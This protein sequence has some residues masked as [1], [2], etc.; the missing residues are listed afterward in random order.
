MFRSLML[1]GALAALTVACA[2]TVDLA[3]EEAALQ[4]IP[5]QWQAFEAEQDAAGVAGLFKD[6]GALYW[7]DQPLARDRAG[8]EAL[9]AKNYKF[10]TGDSSWGVD[11]LLLASSADLAVELGNYSSGSDGGRYA[12]IHQKVD[13][14]WKVHSDFSVGNAPSGGAPEWAVSSLRAWY[15]AYNARDAAAMRAMYSADSRV[16]DTDGMVQG[17]DAIVAR[18]QT[19]WDAGTTCDGDFI[20]FL[21][22][23]PIATAQGRDICTTTAED[24]TTTN[25]YITWITVYEQQADGSWLTIRDGSFTHDS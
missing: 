12:T 24:G 5:Q 23:G 10:P 3:A 6:D 17:P 15:E 7:E 14:E 11:E 22:A 18:M 2:P 16:G 20:E 9:L 13:G 19:S 21:E 25:S 4:Q 1:L 8:V